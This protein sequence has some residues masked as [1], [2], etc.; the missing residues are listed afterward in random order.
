MYDIK[1]IQSIHLNN[2]TPINT[3]KRYDIKQYTYSPMGVD[4]EE[5]LWGGGSPMTFF[6]VYRYT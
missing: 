5:G 2:Q 4:E 1:Y 3:V 6:F